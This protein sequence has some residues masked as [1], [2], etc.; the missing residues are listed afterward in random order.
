M[1]PV[2]ARPDVRA[3]QVSQ[4]VLGAVLEVKE[5]DGDWARV[6]GED[7][8]E[9][10]VSVGALSLC[11]AQQANAWL[12]GTDG[13]VAL[14]LSGVVVSE[15]GG[16]I[17]QL[18]WG[19]RVS[20][21]GSRVRLPDGGWGR[22]KDAQWVPEA[23]LAARYPASGSAIVETAREWMAVPYLWGGRTRWGVDCSGFVQA[24]F[25]FHGVQLPRDSHQQALVGDPVT[26]GDDYAGI[27]RGDLL[28][29]TARES[30]RV[31]HV[32]IS[33]GGPNILHAA[34]A[35][36]RVAEDSL[37]GESELER[38]LSKRLFGVKRLFP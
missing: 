5:P 37:A 10:W 29:F 11:D 35:N 14:V 16:A 32:A 21:S 27:A 7:G 13:R 6:R 30:E 26:H 36:G 28:F 18:P 33:V 1:T 34:Q 31:V 4:E 38:A 23:E 8:Y 22:L 17:A 15:A 9:G 19:A 3:E 2:R 24:V 25:R 20:I 12:G